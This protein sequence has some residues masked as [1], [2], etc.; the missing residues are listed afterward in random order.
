MVKKHLNKHVII[1]TREESLFP[2]I[3][4]NSVELFSEFGQQVV[5]CQCTTIQT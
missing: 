2:T 1:N 4:V 5:C 3:S